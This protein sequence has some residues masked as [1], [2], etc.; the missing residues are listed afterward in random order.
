VQIGVRV[1]AASVDSREDA[2]RTVA[3]EG[4]EFPVACELELEEMVRLAKGPGLPCFAPT[5]SAAGSN[6]AATTDCGVVC[7]RAWA[8]WKDIDTR[9]DFPPTRFMEK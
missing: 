5:S 9:E 1:L 3:K 7:R 2:E 4:L 8:G 6:T